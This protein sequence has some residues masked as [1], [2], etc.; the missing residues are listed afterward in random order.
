MMTAVLIIMGY[1][2]AGQYNVKLPG[3]G[4]PAYTLAPC[5]PLYILLIIGEDER[6]NLQIS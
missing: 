5:T 6:I 2:T 1:A 4:I 3:W